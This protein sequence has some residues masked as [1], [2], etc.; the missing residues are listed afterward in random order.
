MRVSADNIPPALM[1][2]LKGDNQKPSIPHIPEDARLYRLNEYKD[3]YQLSLIGCPFKVGGLVT[4]RKDSPMKGAGGLHVVIAVY[5]P[6]LIPT[7]EDSSDGDFAK[8]R[9]M[10]VAALVQDHMEE[11]DGWRYVE[12]VLSWAANSADFEPYTHK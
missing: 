5:D 2:M 9:N 11:E 3:R 8:V 10:R 7:F 4:P 12:A 6:P 1:A